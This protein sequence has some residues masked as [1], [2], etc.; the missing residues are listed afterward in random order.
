[1]SRSLNHSIGSS[2][3]AT[4][5]VSPHFHFKN[6]TVHTGQIGLSINLLDTFLYPTQL[7][8]KNSGP[9]TIVDGCRY[10][11]NLLLD[12]GSQFGEY[13]QRHEQ[14]TN[15]IKPLTVRA[16]SLCPSGNAQGT[17]YYFSL[18]TDLKPHRHRCNPWQMPSSVIDKFHAMASKQKTLGGISITH[19]DNSPIT[20]SLDDSDAI[21]NQSDDS[22]GVGYNDIKSADSEVH[23]SDTD[24][25]QFADTLDEKLDRDDDEYSTTNNDL[26]LDLNASTLERM[27]NANDTTL[28]GLG[29]ADNEINGVGTEGVDKIEGVGSEGLRGNQM[30]VTPV[31]IIMPS[32]MPNNVMTR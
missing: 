14:I 10:D 12:Q 23:D 28:E 27:G 20:S 19:N 3:N 32:I 26:V 31:M 11:Y 5:C 24:T 8:S 25:D 6:T 18:E 21:Y 30:R 16:L 13:V 1:M 2:K 4:E 9:G 22:E 15:I 7:H 29:N 17:L